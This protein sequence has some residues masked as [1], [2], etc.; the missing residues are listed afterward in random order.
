MLETR[1]LAL[2]LTIVVEWPIAV[3]LAGVRVPA[4]AERKRLRKRAALDALL[5]NVVTNPAVNA[6]ALLWLDADP[7]VEHATM[8]LVLEP[9]VLVVEWAAY[10]LLTFNRKRVGRALLIAVIANAASASLSFLPI[11]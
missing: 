10:A 3:W 9:I 1:L 5:I 8:F 7:F 2:L 11:W 6:V 4:L